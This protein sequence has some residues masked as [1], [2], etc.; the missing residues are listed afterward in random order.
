MLEL[1]GQKNK[2]K[3]KNWEENYTN[4][5]KQIGIVLSLHMWDDNNLK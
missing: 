4:Q 2:L 3:Q 5:S 1:E